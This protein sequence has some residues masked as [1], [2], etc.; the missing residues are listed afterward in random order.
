MEVRSSMVGIGLLVVQ[1][2]AQQPAAA[3]PEVTLQDAVRRALQVQP[4]MV[5]AQGDV[6]NASAAN[7]SSLGAF[8]PTLTVSGSAARNNV[9]VIDRTTGLP[10]PPE[11]S[12]TSGLSASLD[13]FTG[14]RRLFNWRSAGAGGD[15]AAA[16]Y[17]SQRYQVAL[18]TQQDFYDALAREELVRVAQAQLRRA[19]QE[20]QIAVDKL[21][22]GSATRSDSLRAAVDVGTAR[23]QLLQA[24][25]NLATS[26]ATLGRQ[27]GIEGAARAAPD[28]ALPS[29]PDTT[30][31]RAEALRSAPTVR[32]A[33][34]Q[35]RAA[36]ASLWSARSQYLPTLTV[37]YNDN[38][39]G[40]ASPSY[41]RLVGGGYPETF[42]WRFGLS[43]TVFNGFVR[44]Q[45]QTSASVQR[46]VAES[47][48]ADARRQVDAQ[49]TQQLAAL[50]TA[51]T[52]IDISTGQVAA[53]TEDMRVQQERYR[54]GAATIL[55][56]LTSQ[57]NL[58]QAE[59][60][61]VQSRFNYV[62]ARAQLE[63]TVG[64]QL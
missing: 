6:R 56:L 42:S 57:A 25:A 36:G 62:N 19:Q 54:V 33:E 16:G 34:A 35:A 32:Q 26:Q 64:R 58:T 1:L 45:S 44:E 51:F 28:T 14:F 17:V 38:R 15:A 21:K 50:F 49:V 46:D 22:A 48:S 31:L 53:A 2:A 43:W 11:Y 12:Y 20:L 30:G 9:R 8:L 13:L 24:Q 10:V 18:T 52:Q 5:Q 61:L 59:V 3:P 39:Q 7:L 37:S 29:L 41:T 60:N 23:L 4:A 63:A 40:T 27:I 47:R 55:D